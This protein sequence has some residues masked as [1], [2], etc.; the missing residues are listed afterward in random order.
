MTVL[1]IIGKQVD[2]DIE[3]ELRQYSWER[4]RWTADKLIACSPF[5]SDSTPSFFVNLE[6]GGWADSGG[7]G[8]Y[9]NGN[10]LTLI[11]YIRGTSPYEAGEYLIDKYGTL[12]D[13][14]E[15]TDG[16]VSLHIET[17]K[18]RDNAPSVRQIDGENVTQAISPYIKSRGIGDEVQKMF[19][20][21][22][23]EGHEGFTAIP[24]HTTSGRLANVKYRSTSEKRFFY[25]SKATPVTTLVYGL[26]VASGR[27]TAVIVEAEIDSLS[28]WTAG[29][30]A[31][32]LGGAHINDRQAEMIMREGFSEIYLG[33]DNDKQGR[34][35]NRMLADK[36]KGTAQLYEID[37][38]EEKDAN[39]VLQR[40]GV[41]GLRDMITQASPI[42]AIGSPQI[43]QT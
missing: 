28:W 5:R 25:E 18:L 39:D 9:T 8:E 1:R 42:Q 29:I 40:V 37:Y 20:I 15:G 6:S 7:I 43:R 14:S 36:L 13:I 17:P 41:D 16:N 31:V 24:W 21:G 3:A 38:G 35:L 33:G 23:G 19:G 30:P 27:D 32:A 4:E 10:I 11:G 22:Y 12:Y 26:D 34:K 2:V